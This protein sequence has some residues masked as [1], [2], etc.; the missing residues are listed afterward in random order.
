MRKARASVQRLVN[1]E[2]NINTGQTRHKICRPNHSRIRR[3]I[4][5]YRLPC[6]LLLLHMRPHTFTKDIFL[7]SQNSPRRRNLG[8]MIL[9][10]R[11]FNST[12]ER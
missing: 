10:L 1:R 8:I 9:Q 4:M 11:R 2:A 5:K 6:R 3:T 7:N 12:I